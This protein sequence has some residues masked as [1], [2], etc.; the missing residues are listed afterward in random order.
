MQSSNRLCL[1]VELVMHAPEQL[2]IRIFCDDLVKLR[3]QMGSETDI[4]KQNILH[5]PHATC[6]D[7]PI[8][9]CYQP[10]LGMFDGRFH[11]RALPRDILLRKSNLQVVKKLCRFGV[12]HFG[13]ELFEE[14]DKCLLLSGGARLP[15]FAQRALRYRRD[16]QDSVRLL[17]QGGVA[18][19]SAAERAL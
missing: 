11:R 15:V 9:N 2:R 4:I 10:F 13:Q 6:L 16:V 17:G 8:I 1:L 7:K 19:C 12:R 18:A 14:H 5:V 3:L